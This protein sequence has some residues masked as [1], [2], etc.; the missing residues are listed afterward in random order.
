[1]W[2]M[3]RQVRR[4]SEPCVWSRGGEGGRG[5]GNM[6][7]TEMGVEAKWAMLRWVWRLSLIHI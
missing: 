2:V 7:H 6:G 1:M 3:H 5:A 4:E